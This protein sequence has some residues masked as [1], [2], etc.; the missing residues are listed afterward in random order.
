MTQNG[1]AKIVLEDFRMH[2]ETQEA[3]TPLKIAVLD[4]SDMATSPVSSQN[5]LVLFLK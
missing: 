3:L 2:E 5:L 1:E 4:R